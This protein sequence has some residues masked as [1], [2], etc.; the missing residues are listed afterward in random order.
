MLDTLTRQVATQLPPIATRA[1]TREKDSYQIYNNGVLT[2][3]TSVF[4]QVR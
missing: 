3:L 2:E 1:W 4:S